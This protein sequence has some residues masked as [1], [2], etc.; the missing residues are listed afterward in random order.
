M[1]LNEQKKGSAI[2]LEISGRLDATNSSTLENKLFKLMNSGENNIIID[3]KELDYISSSGLR[4]CLVGLKKITA[5][6]GNFLLCSMKD[7]IKQIFD[8]SGFTR[9]FKIFPSQE[10]ALNLINS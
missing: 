2:V 6:K 10:E 9:I 8:I 5:A 1:E 7:N 4:V 3:C